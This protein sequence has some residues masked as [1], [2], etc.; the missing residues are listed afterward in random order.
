[1]GG[2]VSH[3]AGDYREPQLPEGIFEVRLSVYKLEITGVGFLDRVGASLVGAY[4]TGVVVANE[5]WAYGG[6]DVPGKSGVYRTKPELNPDYIFYR[7]ELTGQVKGE[8]RSIGQQIRQLARTE[9][10]AGPRYDLIERNCN[11]FASDLCWMLVGKRPPDWINSTAESMALTRRRQQTEQ[12]ALHAALVEYH[13]EFG[14]ATLSSMASDFLAT[15]DTSKESQMQRLLAAPGAKAFA[16]AFASTFE[17]SFSSAR[18]AIDQA[19]RTCSSGE[20][21]VAV[22]ANEERKQLASASAAS[23]AAARVVARAARAA[24]EARA[25][26]APGAGQDAW[27][28]AWARASAQMLRSWRQEAIAG[29][30]DP[31][32]SGEK[33][34]Q[35]ARQVA[36]AL[37]DAA[38]GA[39]AAREKEQRLATRR[40]ELEKAVE[41][42]TAVR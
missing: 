1:M 16:D 35:R 3:Q 21:P 32:P 7:R 37:E 40:A 27:D 2:E 29:T 38:R 28:G 26:Q 17:L 30:L 5:E 4:H 36:A 41:D 25:G 13:T 6:H 31:S 22:R 20:D 15:G 24:A 9:K 18:D 10:W 12:N 23:L 34:I 11:H 39:A 14:T 19:A 42:A 8:Y 33:G